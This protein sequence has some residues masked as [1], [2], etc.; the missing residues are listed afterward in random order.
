MGCIL[1]VLGDNFVPEPFLAHSQLSPYT[2]FVKGV[3]KADRL[4]VSKTSGFNCEVSTSDELEE[5]IRDAGSFLSQ[6]ESDLIQ[7]GH[8][9]SIESFFLDFC[10]LCGTGIDIPIRRAVFPHEFLQN[11]SRF[12]I[13]ICISV[14]ISSAGNA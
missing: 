11:V 3:R 14:F 2:T 13:D 4:H 12:G 5:Q 8:Q 10:M 9:D 6:F 1:R 7:L